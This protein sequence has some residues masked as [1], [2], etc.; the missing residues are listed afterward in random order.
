MLKK[1]T[2]AAKEKLKQR[3]QH[4]Q[5]PM[6]TKPRSHSNRAPMGSVSFSAVDNAAFQDILD[7][8]SDFMCDFNLDPQPAT[9][10]AS[11]PGFNMSK[12]CHLPTTSK[13]GESDI[14]NA[15]I[16]DVDKHETIEEEDEHKNGEM[17]MDSGPLSESMASQHESRN[18]NGRENDSNESF[19]EEDT[20]WNGKIGEIGTND[21]NGG[22]CDLSVTAPSEHMLEPCSD[23]PLFDNGNPTTT[24]IATRPIAMSLT[25][26][27]Q[28][29]PHDNCASFEHRRELSYDSESGL[30]HTLSDVSPLSSSLPSSFATNDV[31]SSL[32]PSEGASLLRDQQRATLTTDQCSPCSVDPD[33]CTSG[34]IPPTQFYNKGTSNSFKESFSTGIDSELEQLLKSPMRARSSPAVSKDPTKGSIS[35]NHGSNSPN[36]GSNS[37]NHGSNSPTKGSISPRG[38]SKSPYDWTRGRE[39]RLSLGCVGNLDSGVFD[40]Y[41]TGTESDHASDREQEKV[42]EMQDGLKEIFS[43][44]MALNVEEEHFAAVQEHLPVRSVTPS[45]S[46]GHTHFAPATPTNNFNDIHPS[47]SSSSPSPMIPP[48]SGKHKATPPPRPLLSPQVRKKFN[49]KLVPPA[50]GNVGMKI[51]PVGR[52]KDRNQSEEVVNHQVQLEG[53]EVREMVAQTEVKLSHVELEGPSAQVGRPSFNADMHHH[54]DTSIINASN[55]F[56]EL[57]TST[58][59][60]E[61]NEL[62]LTLPYHLALSVILYL[63]YSLNIFPYLA[64]LFA[65]F[66]TLFLFLGSVFIYY[67]HAIEREQQERSQQLRDV[68]LSDDFVQTMKADFIKLEVYQV[69]Q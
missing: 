2:G 69:R 36:H 42:G 67:V 51:L 56:T 3:L 66:L 23:T 68:K 25:V 40:H 9:S 22:S 39:N 30:S 27:D 55:T 58:E 17:M 61:D 63:Y 32:S 48:M 37:P 19:N 14:F 59:M 10:S 11:S 18:G 5:I 60:E 64:G 31:H 4:G 7:D 43:N 50:A 16:L 38:R 54:G 47:S 34:P 15:D 28:L 24:T 35:P 8:E 1:V 65:G 57:T 49:A 12:N 21:E 62:Y 53:E 13:T 20:I 33:N 41:A 52:R 44:S 29:S 6:P 46:N 26:D 45:K